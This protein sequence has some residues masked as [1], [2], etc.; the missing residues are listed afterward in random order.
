M[1]QVGVGPWAGGSRIA[2]LGNADVNR[3]IVGISQ[4]TLLFSVHRISH[5]PTEFD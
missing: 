1:L 4:W 3:R 5:H 2:A